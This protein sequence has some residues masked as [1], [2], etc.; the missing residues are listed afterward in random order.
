MLPFS[1]LALVIR[2]S[3]VLEDRHADPPPGS[4]SVLFTLIPIAVIV[5]WAAVLVGR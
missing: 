3:H 1:N 4:A 5:A 2:E